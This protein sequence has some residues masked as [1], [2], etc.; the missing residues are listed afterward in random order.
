MFVVAAIA[1]LG[2]AWIVGLSTERLGAITGPQVGGILNAT[3]G[4]IAE[5]IIAFFA[6]QAGLH[7]R[8]QGVAHGLDHRQPAARARGRG[9]RR[10]AAQRPPDVQPADRGLERGAA[11][12]RRGRPVHPGRVRG[13]RLREPGDA[14]R[15]VGPRR[16]RAD[17]R[18]RAV[19]RV[20][21]HQPRGDARRPRPS[22]KG[23]RAR[24]DRQGRR[25]RP[26]RRGRAAR[27]CCRRSSSAR[28]S[29]S[30]SSSACP[31]CSSASSSSR[32]SATSPST[33]S[34]SSSRARTRWS[35]RWP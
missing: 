5:L 11:R 16:G 28:S 31:S 18:L 25:R 12:A 2:L 7:H 4:N 20:A 17:R 34:R 22:P 33:S 14:R 8:R 32:R 27:A 21:V 30:S 26:A 24:L 35:S 29:R 10:R 19:A 1:I 23:T 6:L 15:G 9:A 13:Q 3:F